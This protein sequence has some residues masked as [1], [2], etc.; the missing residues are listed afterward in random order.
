MTHTDEDVHALRVLKHL[1][2]MKKRYSKPHKFNSVSRS[3]TTVSA[4]DL[5]V[6]QIS[7]MLTYL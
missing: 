7:I 4:L 3:D 1:T 5:S 2:L 6:F